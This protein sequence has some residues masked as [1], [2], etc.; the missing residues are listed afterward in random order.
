MAVDR[1]AIAAYLT[2]AYDTL[3]VDFGLPVADAG[4]ALKAPIDRA[5]M[6]LGVAHADLATGET[7]SEEA[8]FVLASYYL[9]QKLQGSTAARNVNVSMGDPNTSKGNDAR[10]RNL[11][12]AMDAVLAEMVRLGVSGAGSWFAGSITLDYLEPDEEV[13]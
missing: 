9:L 8:A 13:A 2:D 12:D 4:G 11:K 7:D 6:R 10:A 5:L 3:L 1:A